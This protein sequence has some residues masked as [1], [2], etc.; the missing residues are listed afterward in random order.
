MRGEQALQ[1]AIAGQFEGLGTATEELATDEDLRDGAA[2]GARGEHRADLPTAIVLLGRGKMTFTPS[3]AAVRTQVRIFSGE[4]VLATD[5]DA[6]FIR[7][8]PGEADDVLPHAA[9]KPVPVA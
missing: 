2:A 5:F 1:A 8:R 4:N 9:L 7:V 6:V 3:D